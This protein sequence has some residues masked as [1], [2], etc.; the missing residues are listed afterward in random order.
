MLWQTLKWQKIPISKGEIL[1][2][3]NMEKFLLFEL[4]QSGKINLL[5]FVKVKR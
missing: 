1:S 5:A 2:P 3:F 4:R